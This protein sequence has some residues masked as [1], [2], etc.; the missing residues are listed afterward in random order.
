M[1]LCTSF[2][3]RIEDIILFNIIGFH[4]T[5]CKVSQNPIAFEVAKLSKE[6]S[7]NSLHQEY[8]NILFLEILGE[9]TTML[10]LEFII[11]RDREI[12]EHCIFVG[13]VYSILFY[14]LW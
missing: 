4:L 8:R 3:Y 14:S 7:I 5:D 1:E 10:F 2:R 6:S 9:N 12:S 13:G 11:S